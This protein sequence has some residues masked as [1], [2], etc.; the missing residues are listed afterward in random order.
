MLIKSKPD[1]FFGMAF[2]LHYSII[3]YDI[4]NSFLSKCD[5]SITEKLLKTKRLIQAEVQN[6]F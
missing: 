4:S 6:P 1:I 5:Q 2:F 3:H